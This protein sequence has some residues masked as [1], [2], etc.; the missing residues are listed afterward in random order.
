MRAVITRPL[1][2]RPRLANGPR[3]AYS[4]GTSGV[5]ATRPEVLCTTARP[6]PVDILP[7]RF[8]FVM[9]TSPPPVVSAPG[10]VVEHDSAAGGVAAEAAL[11][12]ADPTAVG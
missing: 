9:L 5:T 11:D 10:D 2:R 7:S 12:A 6:P 8:E 4:D 3:S 1:G